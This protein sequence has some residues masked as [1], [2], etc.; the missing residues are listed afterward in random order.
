MGLGSIAYERSKLMHG[1][2]VKLLTAEDKSL[3][4]DAACKLGRQSYESPKIEY[5][6]YER[7]PAQIDEIFTYRS[8]GLAAVQCVK[9]EGAG[10]NICSQCH[11]EIQCNNVTEK[12]RS[13]RLI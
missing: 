8:I 6:I 2:V 3:M 11:E 5:A 7:Q 9:G 12:K 1:R 13:I 10:S 4:S